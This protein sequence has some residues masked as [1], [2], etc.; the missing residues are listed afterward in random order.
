MYWQSAILL[1][2][3]FVAGSVLS[4]RVLSRNKKYAKASFV[5][6][7]EQYLSLY[8]SM[9]AVALIL[10]HIDGSM[11]SHYWWRFAVGG[12]AFALTNV[13]MYK[14]LVYFDAAIGSIV[15]TLNAIFA[16]IG[17]SIVLNEILSPQQLIGAVILLCA[18]GYGLLATHSIHKKIARHTLKL[19]IMY[20]FLAGIFFMIAAVNEKSLLEHMSDGTYMIFGVGWQCL[21]AVILGVAVQPRYL[22]ILWQPHVAVWSLLSGLLRGLGGAFFIIAEVNSN[23]VGLIS[24]IANFRLIIVIFLGAWLLKERDHLRQKLVSAMTSL[25]GMAIMFWK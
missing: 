23:N 11:L 4:L 20:A 8:I 22:R 9:V 12:L 5:I 25:I 19:G 17:A 2:T 10:G 14:T 13:C 21:V 16:V 6:N 1:Q 7:G 24:V 15:A 3:I 18:V